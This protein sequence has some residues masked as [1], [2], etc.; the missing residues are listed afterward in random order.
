MMTN[1]RVM[2]WMYAE[3]GLWVDGWRV[4]GYRC[5]KCGKANLNKTNYCPHCGR[6]CEEHRE[7]KRNDLLERMEKDGRI[8][9]GHTCA[10]GPDH[11][12][13]G[14]GQDGDGQ[15]GGAGAD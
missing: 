13:C 1:D 7:S 3:G 9:A 12:G 5:S 8:G 14:A 4:D 15:S 11:N 6:E 10:G 2:R